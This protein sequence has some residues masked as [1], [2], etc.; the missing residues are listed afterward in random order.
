MLGQSP[1]RHSP[2]DLGLVKKLS[3]TPPLHRSELTPQPMLLQERPPALPD[4]ALSDSVLPD[5][6]NL[7]HRALVSMLG[8][9]I[10]PIYPGTTKVDFSRVRRTVFP[11]A[12]EF[13]LNSLLASNLPREQMAL[14]LL[15]LFTDFMETFREFYYQNLS[16]VLF[17]RL[18]WSYMYEALKSNRTLAAQYDQAIRHYQHDQRDWNHIARCLEKILKLRFFRFELMKQLITIKPEPHEESI[19]YADRIQ[20]LVKLSRA[21]REGT[22][23]FTISVIAESLPDGGYER[24]KAHF[25]SEDAIRTVHDIVQFIRKTPGTL[26]GRTTDRAEWVW[27][28]FR[29]EVESEEKQALEEN[30]CSVQPEQESEPLQELQQQ[31]QQ[32]RTSPI[33]EQQQQ[34]RTLP[35]QEQQPPSRTH[36]TQEQQQPSRAHPTQEQQQS[37]QQSQQHQQQQEAF[38]KYL[39][40]QQ[41]QQPSARAEE[42][43]RPRKR[44]R[45]DDLCNEDECIQRNA[46]HRPEV[47][48]V[49][50][51]HLFYEKRQDSTRPPRRED[52]TSS[53]TSR[54]SRREENASTS[55]GARCTEE[56]CVKKR[57]K[58]RQSECW[59]RNP[60]LRRE[61]PSRSTTAPSN[62]QLDSSS[63]SN[64]TCASPFSY[65]E[66]TARDPSLCPEEDCVNRNLKHRADQ[67][68][69]RHPQLR[70]SRSKKSARAAAG[71]DTI[72]TVRFEDPNCGEDECLQNHVLHRPEEC[73]V[74][75]RD[76]DPDLDHIIY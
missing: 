67:C 3:T 53:S 25:G 50:H 63:T 42:S 10:I 28:H 30:T 70:V 13:H 66:E 12:P 58:H 32:S 51:P 29:Q 68:W 18:A 55:A 36:S 69:I 15:R 16:S 44:R 60:H 31:Q 52:S 45:S 64:S 54:P 59:I 46:F 17:D 49:R 34:S 71:T 41:Q 5:S 76:V 33:Q 35:S 39:Q 6:S 40:Q 24:V 75:Y 73:W 19:A 4:G 57:L 47:C 8:D 27:K 14:S 65:T 74:R 9:M 26:S 61:R 72:R 7:V 48:W 37:R 56:S 1:D 23:R 21:D 20:Q 38:E 11:G 43:E 22:E 2:V 62:Y